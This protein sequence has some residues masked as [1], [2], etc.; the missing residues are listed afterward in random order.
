MKGEHGKPLI[1]SRYLV[2]VK[3]YHDDRDEFG[4]VYVGDE[5]SGHLMYVTDHLK[6]L[7]SKN[8]HDMKS[9]RIRA[10]DEMRGIRSQGFKVKVEVVDQFGERAE[11][12]PVPHRR[13]YRRAGSP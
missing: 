12:L 5:A 10:D 2:R 9:L 11:D 1:E 4:S 13:Q 6:A 7:C 3:I 8:P